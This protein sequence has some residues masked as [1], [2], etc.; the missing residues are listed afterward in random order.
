MVTDGTVTSLE[1]GASVL[2]VSEPPLSLLPQPTAKASTAAPPASVS[3]AL[4]VG[5]PK[6]MQSHFLSRDPCSVPEKP[7]GKPTD[8][9]RQAAITLMSSPFR[10]ISAV[11]DVA[12][13][14]PGA[15]GA[16]E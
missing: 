14:V 10:Y 2:L 6:G 3:A 1:V 4:D 5:F 15:G 11:L 8:P 9:G 16:T 13:G 12:V 7:H